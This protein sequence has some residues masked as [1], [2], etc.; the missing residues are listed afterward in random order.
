VSREIPG[1]RVLRESRV[2]LVPKE[3]KAVREQ[4]E[5]RALQEPKEQLELRD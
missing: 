3:F 5:L 4:L 2:R 1:P